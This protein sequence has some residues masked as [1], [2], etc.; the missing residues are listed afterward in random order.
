MSQYNV[1]VYYN[2]DVTSDV[3]I[4]SRKQE[5]ITNECITT[6]INYIFKFKLALYVLQCFITKS[7]FKPKLLL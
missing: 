3:T 5:L 4:K 2:V 7:Y 6:H 1:D